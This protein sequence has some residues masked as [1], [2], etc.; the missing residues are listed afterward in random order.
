MTSI[1]LSGSAHPELTR[2]VALR[3]G[4]TTA[5]RILERFPDGELR[6]LV[7]EPVRGADVYLVQPLS[8]PADA[9]LLELVFLADACRRAGARSVTAVVPYL[10]WA[11]QDRRRVEGEPHGARLA[12]DLI[13]A[14]ADRVVSVDVHGPAAEGFFSVPF[15]HLT[16][17][18]A[19][20]AAIARSAPRDAV[21]VGPDLGAARRAALFGRL[22]GLPS[23][24][25]HKARLSAR[26]V[27]VRGVAGEV[28]GRAPILVDD[29]ISTG[30][31]IEAAVRTLLEAGCRPEIVVAATHPLFT[32][33]A[34]ERLARL[35]IARVVVTDALPV[36]R[37]PG[38]DLEVVPLAPLLA[39]AISRLCERR[40]LGELLSTT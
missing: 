36:P 35:P 3:L 38:H 25:V 11:R 1:V 20:A 13:S 28:A 22:L 19:L 33:G 23:A 32:E 40:P 7:K 15:D 12:A 29:M 5:E 31:T 4:L 37:G 8:P 34:L 21:V 27:E 16:A 26:E 30:A 2:D 6:V 24:I 9:H 10:A 18:P 14:R 17:V 39:E